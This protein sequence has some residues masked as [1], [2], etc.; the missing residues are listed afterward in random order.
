MVK[1]QNTMKMV[2]FNLVEMN[3]GHYICM[4]QNKYKQHSAD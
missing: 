2:C 3:R 1:Y 4:S